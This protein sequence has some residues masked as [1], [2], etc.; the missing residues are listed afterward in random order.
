MDACD[1]IDIDIDISDTIH[2]H[3]TQ[4]SF[5]YMGLT[6]EEC[7]TRYPRYRAMQHLIAAEK[8]G[9]DIIGAAAW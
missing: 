4:L 2:D 9:G 3:Y 1:L 6:Y 5:E 8:R 7:M